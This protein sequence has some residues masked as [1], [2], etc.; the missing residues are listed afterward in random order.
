ML[1]C[2]WLLFLQPTDDPDALCEVPHAGISNN[3]GGVNELS[4]SNTTSETSDNPKRRP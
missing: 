1:R 2:V 3:E 4:T